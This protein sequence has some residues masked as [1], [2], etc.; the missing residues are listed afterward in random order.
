M[1]RASL[2]RTII[3]LVLVLVMLTIGKTAL[4][5]VNIF[6][7]DILVPPHV[8]VVNTDD[9]WFIDA[10]L[11]TWGEIE[12]HTLDHDF[13]FLESLIRANVPDDSDVY[14]YG[15]GIYCIGGWSQY[16]YIETTP[17]SYNPWRDLVIIFNTR[18]GTWNIITD[19]SDYA[20]IDQYN[21]LQIGIEDDSQ[22]DFYGSPG[23]IA[24]ITVI[25]KVHTY[26]GGGGCE[27]GD[28]A[29]LS[30]LLLLAPLA[31]LKLRRLK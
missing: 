19:A 5:Q 10:W 17:I 8:R 6:Y 3:L 2:S 30:W 18:T 22:Y 11:S 28:G 29:N 24:F 16:L 12:N 31:M 13:W 7:E 15:L 14:L 25:A 4:A 26:G 23:E 21:P 9:G 1:R 20:Y 27:V